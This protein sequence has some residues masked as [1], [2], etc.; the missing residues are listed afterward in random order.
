M[1]L[2]VFCV[3]LFML[4]GFAR[5]LALEGRLSSTASWRGQDWGNMLGY[6]FI[7]LVRLAFVAGVGVQAGPDEGAVSSSG[8]RQRHGKTSA[9]K[10]R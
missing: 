7:G 5:G 3:D 2:A 8:S 4:L 10:S 6:T 1:N 9:S